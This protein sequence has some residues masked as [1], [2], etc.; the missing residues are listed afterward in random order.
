MVTKLYKEGTLNCPFLLNHSLPNLMFFTIKF[1]VTEF[2]TTL[3]KIFSFQNDF[4]L[5]KPSE[6]INT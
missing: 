3:I 4:I 1:I 6:I 2:M 5:R